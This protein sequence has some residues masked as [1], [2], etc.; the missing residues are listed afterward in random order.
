[1][2]PEEEKQ[3]IKSVDD[4]R[5]TV[6]EMRAD[7]WSLKTQV[8]KA[9]ERQAKTGEEVEQ[10]IVPKEEVNETVTDLVPEQ[11]EAKYEMR[12]FRKRNGRIVQRKV[13]V[14]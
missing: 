9:D 13:R 14:N 11:P 8:N 2:E 4:L 7:I 10:E 5:E 1:M 12:L 6:S 3:L